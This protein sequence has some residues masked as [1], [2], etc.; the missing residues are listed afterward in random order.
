[1]IRPRPRRYFTLMAAVVNI[2]RFQIQVSLCVIIS[3]K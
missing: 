1:M 2:G 3:V